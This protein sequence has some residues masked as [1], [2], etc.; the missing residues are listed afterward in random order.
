[1]KGRQQTQV[2]IRRHDERTV[3]KRANTGT[4]ATHKQM[5]VGV[6]LIGTGQVSFFFFFFVVVVVVVFC[7]LVALDEQIGVHELLGE[8]GDELDGGRRRVR[9]EL[10]ESDVDDIVASF[11]DEAEPGGGQVAWRQ[12]YDDVAAL[13]PEV[14]DDEA[15]AADETDQEVAVDWLAATGPAM[16][17]AEPA[18]RRRHGRRGDVD[19]LLGVEDEA[20]QRGRR[21]GDDRRRRRRRESKVKAERAVRA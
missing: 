5:R 13:G 21:V 1:M 4:Q 12:R 7:H 10:V 18:A 19:L 14:V 9:V 20:A 11:V 15:L 6:L 2:R 17:V 3:E 8:E 16:L